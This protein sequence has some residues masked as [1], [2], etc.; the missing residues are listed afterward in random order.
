MADTIRQEI[1]KFLLN[2]VKDDRIGFVTITEVKMTADLQTARVYYTSYGTEKQREES[3]LGLQ[4]S[5]YKIRAHLGKTL[6]FRYTPRLEFFF[7]RGL[8]HSY[9]I[10]KLLG[11]LTP[12]DDPSDDSE[13]K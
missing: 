11:E 12:P 8:E 6:R 9:K 1:A 4:Q 13:P 5:S 2:G 7:D 3:E 10:Q